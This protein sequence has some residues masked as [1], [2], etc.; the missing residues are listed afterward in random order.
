MTFTVQTLL[1]FEVNQFFKIAY[2]Y[3]LSY[4]VQNDTDYLILEVWSILIK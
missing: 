2:L 1:H 4:V 3:S